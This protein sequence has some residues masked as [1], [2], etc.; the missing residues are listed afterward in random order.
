[1]TRQSSPR[2]RSGRVDPDMVELAQ[3]LQ[4][5][6]FF[7][8][9]SAGCHFIQQNILLSPSSLHW[10]VLMGTISPWPCSSHGEYALC[11]VVSSVCP[12]GVARRGLTVLG[13]VRMGVCTCRQCL[14][15]PLG[16]S[17]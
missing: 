4:G 10:P 16:C 6:S 14:G 7:L 12:S 13:H 1:V 2:W 5:P 11:H 3:E 15:L 9:V 17:R 8:I